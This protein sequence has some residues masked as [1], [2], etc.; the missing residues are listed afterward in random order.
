[1]ILFTLLL[2]TLHIGPSS[3]TQASTWLLGVTAGFALAVA[4]NHL[5]RLREE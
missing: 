2:I 4:L 5:I 3:S 1:M